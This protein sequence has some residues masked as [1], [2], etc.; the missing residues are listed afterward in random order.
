MQWYTVFVI[1]PP[2]KGDPK[3]GAKFTRIVRVQ[4]FDRQHA[5][6]LAAAK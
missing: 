6:Q 5:A 1:G 2:L 3:S 4:A